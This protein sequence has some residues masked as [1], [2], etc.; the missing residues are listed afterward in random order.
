MWGCAGVDGLYIE[1]SYMRHTAVDGGYIYVSRDGMEVCTFSESEG[2]Q[3]LAWCEP[4]W[5]EAYSYAVYPD[6]MKRFITP[7]L[8][9][10]N[11]DLESMRLSILNVEGIQL[12]EEQQA[13]LADIDFYYQ[14]EM[15]DDDESDKLE[16]KWFAKRC[17]LFTAQQRVDIVSRLM[18]EP[19]LTNVARQAIAWG[20]FRFNY[21]FPEYNMTE[22]PQAALQSGK[23][24]N[25]GKKAR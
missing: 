22:V 10:R 1:P 14:W 19:R 11:L 7:L 20:L 25:G 15:L 17:L 13:V 16:N 6:S 8:Q 23:K 21:M 5:V 18:D 9:A 2:F 4:W 24:E 3:V 12:K